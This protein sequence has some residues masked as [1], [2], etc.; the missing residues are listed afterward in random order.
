MSKISNS[1]KNVRVVPYN[2][3]KLKAHLNIWSEK[4]DEY[5][6]KIMD[7]YRAIKAHISDVKEDLSRKDADVIYNLI[8]ESNLNRN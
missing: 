5:E 7:E 6:K 2:I 1:T 3:K 4:S 8:S